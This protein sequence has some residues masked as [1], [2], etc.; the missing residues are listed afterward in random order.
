MNLALRFALQL[1]KV[2]GFLL[3]EL[4]Q[5]VMSINTWANKEHN[6]DGTHADVTMD[7]LVV[8]SIQPPSDLTGA[9][10][11]S[12][13]APYSS[14]NQRA[15]GP[16][17]YLYVW[18]A[19]IYDSITLGAATSSQAV[20]D[21]SSVASNAVIRVTRGIMPFTDNTVDLGSALSP[22]GVGSQNKRWRHVSLAGTLFFGSANSRLRSGTGTPEGTLTGNIGDI[23][24]R[25][26]GGASTVLYIKESG[27]GSTGWI[28]K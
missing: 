22:P 25:T 26:D 16:F 6:V 14:V 5:I 18:T 2:A 3:E 23:F 4:T 15:T 28:A 21:I 9:T 27:T 12:I 7:S 8:G 11:S 13:G 24:I 10:A 17:Q 1:G 19:F 20:I